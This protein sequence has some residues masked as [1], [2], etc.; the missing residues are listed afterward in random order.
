M[1]TKVWKVRIVETEGERREKRG[2]KEMRRKRET[3]V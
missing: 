3:K 1:E 2:G